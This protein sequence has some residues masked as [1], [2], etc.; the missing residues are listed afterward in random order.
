[1]SY[2]ASWNY[3]KGKSVWQHFTGG[4]RG[5]RKHEGRL[6]SSNI[7]KNIINCCATKAAVSI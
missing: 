1:M 5:G 4:M 6:D 7:L 3:S 2:S